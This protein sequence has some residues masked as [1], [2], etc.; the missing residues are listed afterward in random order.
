MKFDSLFEP[1]AKAVFFE[2]IVWYEDK[3]PGLGKEFAQEVLEAVDRAVTQ[4]EIFRMVRGRARKVRLKRFNAF[5]IYFAIKDDVF[6]VVSVFH[7][8]RNPAE[9]RRRLK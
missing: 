6:S 7:S 5:S 1:E 9:L 3:S 2:A 4:P 8:A